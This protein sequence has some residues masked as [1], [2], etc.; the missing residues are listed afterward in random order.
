MGSSWSEKLLC[1]ESL[2]DIEDPGLFVDV[3]NFYQFFSLGQSPGG[4]QSLKTKCT[5]QVKS[6]PL[7]SCREVV[8][9]KIVFHTEELF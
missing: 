1:F 6:V 2:Q 8:F 7:V 4:M 3:A 9:V 5:V